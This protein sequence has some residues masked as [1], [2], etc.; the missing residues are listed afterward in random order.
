[1]VPMQRLL[2]GL[3]RQIKAQEITRKRPPAFSPKRVAR[4]KGASIAYQS[5]IVKPFLSR[6]GNVARSLKPLEYE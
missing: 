1:M 5:V 6:K 3:V 4:D 2:K